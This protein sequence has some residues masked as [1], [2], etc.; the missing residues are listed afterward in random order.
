MRLSEL[1]IRRPVLTVVLSLLIL[2]LGSLSLL[3]LPVREYPAVDPPTVS[4]TTAYPG[5][6]AEV[7]QAQVTE[8]I[9][10]AVN[11]VA[12]IVSLTSTS[13]EGASVVTAE[14]SLDTDLDTA[15]SDVRDQL[16][17]AARYLPPDVNPPILNK[18]NADSSPIF[19]IALS[20]QTLS[21]LALGAYADSLR[22]RLQTVPGIAA[23]EMPS[24]KR[25]AMRLWMDPERLAAYGISPLDVRAA[26]A[27]ESVELP[28]G[29][30]EGGAVEFPVKTLSRLNSVAEFNDLVIRRSDDR[31]VRFSDVGYAQ[32]GAQNERGALKMDGMPIA[33]IYFKQQ[34]GAN[35]IE[36]VNELRLRIEQV[37]RELPQDIQLEVAYDNTSYVRRSLLE[38]AETI[39]IAFALVLL[40][41]FAFLREWRTTLIPVLAIPVSIVGSFAVIDAAGFSINVLTLLGIVL[42]IGLVVDDAIV[43]LENV[44]AKVEGGM[45]PLTAGIRGSAEIVTAVISTTITL[46]V[47]FLP[48]LFMGG[49]SGRL[50]RE[51]G[52]TIAGAV[53]ISAFVALTLTPML[54]TR[55]LR[56][57]TRRSWFF[58]VS[59]PWLAAM[60]R[61]YERSL[62]NFLRFRVA[63]PLILV[64][65]VALGIVLFLALPRELSP[66]EDRSRLWVRATA[67]EGVSYDYMQNY[68]DDVATATREAV[69]D[70]DVM[71]TQVPGS[72]GSQGVQGMV[73]SGF[74]RIFLKD[75]PERR[76][77]QQRIAQDLR[78]LQ[79]RFP[80]ARLNITQENSIG[81]RRTTQTGVQFVLQGPDVA[82]LRDVLP[83]FLDEARKSPVFSFVDSDLKFSKPEL[84]VI[85][86]RE[87]AQALGISVQSIAETLQAALSGQRLGYFIQAGKQYDVIGQLTRDFRSRPDDL[88]NISV[89]AADGTQ[90]RLDNLVVL[91]ESSAPPELYRYNR[92]SAAT[93]SGTLAGSH[94]IADG[95]AA[96]E[97]AAAT[98]LDDRFST[99]LTGA[100]KDFVE[101]SSSLGYVFLLAL[102]LIYLV[103]AAQFESFL[104]PLVILLTVPLAIAGALLSLW[105]F[106]QTLNIF[107]QIGLIMLIGLVTKNGILIVEFANQRHALGTVDRLIAVREA[108]VTRLR[109]ILMTTLATALGIL[110]IALAL[111]AGSESRVSMGIAVIGGLMFGSVLTLYVIPAMYALLHRRGAAAGSGT[112]AGMTDLSAAPA[113]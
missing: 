64:G 105:Y 10:E 111:G 6:A 77:S 24:E 67:A 97:A 62:A 4:I 86:N 52:V 75:Q 66:L 45:D 1:S 2:L 98:A 56:H 37:R 17:R 9:E 113:R 50:F 90:V 15:A 54:A 84:Q 82:A 99:S 19:G 83:A 42:A 80:G 107:S 95:I 12:G 21:Q 5:A 30:I 7:V 29:R 25:Y 76:K 78:A 79:A 85:I 104:S 48:L 27:R 44:Y 92:Y 14:F 51:F 47:V 43:V 13:R 26:L 34:P 8:P 16:S 89:R 108:A 101:S 103:L 53:L 49:L 3:R 109:P 38:V 58:R 102:V 41:V 81:E 61:A 68:M 100:A 39:F 22:E 55:L 71:M 73:N 59:A 32:L 74:V 94:T 110:P 23:V 18:A 72:G 33:G 63:A 46:A 57:D 106:D 88:Q 70:A 11:S 31:V 35:Q 36:I 28:S 69:P 96:L 93:I 20:S 91:H 87:K 112:Q 65:A 60:E 40:V